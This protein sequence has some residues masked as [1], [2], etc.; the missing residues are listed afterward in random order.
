[1]E[2]VENMTSTGLMSTVNM[3]VWK[4]SAL[5][6][7]GEQDV[8]QTLTVLGDVELRGPV[9]GKGRLG[10]VNLVEVKDNITRDI[11]DVHRDLTVCK[12]HYNRTFALTNCADASILMS[13]CF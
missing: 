3:S 10:S 4:K 13:F 2:V 8:T 7:E 5:T 1:M 11:L 9:H 12:L 6:Y